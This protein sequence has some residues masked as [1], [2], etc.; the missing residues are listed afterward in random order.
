MTDDILII[1]IDTEYEVLYLLSRKNI[2]FSS[3]F[4]SIKTGRTSNILSK[5]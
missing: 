2:I 5:F 3:F 1:N 4:I